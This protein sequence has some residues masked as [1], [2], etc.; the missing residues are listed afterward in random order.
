MST[1]PDTVTHILEMAKSAGEVSARKMFGEYA[2]YLDGKVVGLICDDRLFLKPVPALA[3]LLPDA[4][5]APPYPG[6]RPHI[7]P[8]AALDDPALLAQ[9]L[10]LV[11]DELP[12]PKPKPGRRK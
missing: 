8:D 7:A 3:A 4:E 1:R 6:A 9:A 12:A 10:R 5:D 2:L 11:A